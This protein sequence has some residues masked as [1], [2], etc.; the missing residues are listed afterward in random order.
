VPAFLF[1][2]FALFLPLYLFV[3]ALYFA[4][5]DRRAALASL[6][7][8]FV[9]AGLYVTIRLWTA[10]VIV[11][12]FEPMAASGATIFQFLATYLILV[13]WYA[14]RLFYPVDITFIY[15]TPIVRDHAL[16]LVLVFLILTFLVGYSILKFRHQKNIVIPL[17]FLMIGF[18]GAAPASFTQSYQGLII[19]P[20]WFYFSSIGFFLLVAQGIGALKK[21]VPSPY[22]YA[23]VSIV[24]G[25]LSVAT[26][27]YN[28]L[29]HDQKSYCRH[30][31]KLL[32]DNP[33]ASFYL[34]ES[35]MREGEYKKAEPYLYKA[36]ID[37]RMDAQVYANLGLIA[38]EEKNYDKARKFYI[39]AIE[40]DPVYA[41][42]Y[43]NLGL[44]YFEEEQWETAEKLFKRAIQ[45][46]HYLIESRLN[47]ARIYER[48]DN[49]NR[50][51]DVYEECL[52]IN[53]KD[54]RCL[55]GLLAHYLGQR[56]HHQALPFARRLLQ[57]G[58]DADILINAGGLCARQNLIQEATLLYLK[59]L[60]LAPQNKNGYKELGKL[61]GN[62]GDM[63]RAI[64]IWQKGLD[65]DPNDQEFPLL[66][67]QAQELKK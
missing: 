15:S 49:F 60:G 59:A 26:I 28:H 64:Q 1:Y 34:S 53:P 32:P 55:Y 54:D 20:H 30:W 24:L 17:S 57:A 27:S 63:D 4:N 45:F 42:P 7:F 62:L 40:H 19:E 47:L 43:N 16:W 48:T 25:L 35:Y 52:K 37:Q 46:N 9:L 18:I 36:I 29:W 39:R 61:Y 2:E 5:H 13:G 44:I 51:V 67:Q 33:S 23:F 58:R 3:V 12:V 10:S 66:I 14:S 50:L 11:S 21:C 56:N 22:V 41:I 65:Y 6:I 8:Y 38:F 31:L